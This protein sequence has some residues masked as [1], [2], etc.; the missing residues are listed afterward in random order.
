MEASSPATSNSFDSDA[1]AFHFRA[2][3]YPRNNDRR[4]G[5]HRTGAAFTVVELLVVVGIITILVALLMPAL[6]KARQVSQRVRCASNLRQI[7]MATTTYAGENKNRIPERWRPGY[8]MGNV[9]PSTAFG[10]YTSYS[11]GGF[12]DNSCNINSLVEK[13]YL[14]GL[15]IK[16]DP[17]VDV[18]WLW[19][20]AA[21]DGTSAAPGNTSGTGGGY[22]SSYFF[23][24]HT[25]VP[26]AAS[27]LDSRYTRID[28]I[29]RNRCVVCDSV[30]AL[31]ALYHMS[32]S[33]TAGWNLAF[34]DAHVVFIESKQLTNYI[35]TYAG[36]NGWGSTFQTVAAIDFLE[37]MAEGGD[38]LKQ[39][40]MGPGNYANFSSAP[41]YGI[42]NI[43]T[44]RVPQNP[45][46]QADELP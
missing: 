35:Q 18:P 14:S 32:S 7:V 46:E 21:I 17:E 27:G 4:A 28:K 26:T 33:S 11:W 9:R 3:S 15:F 37:T 2:D 36:G 29:P 20:P 5:R 41:F 38:P 44:N 31:D 16:D 43:G 22:T 24:P 8:D 12:A 34:P 6:S 1:H 23:N 19:C 10:S 39:S 45:P 42:R 40:I 25:R 30:Y 13:G